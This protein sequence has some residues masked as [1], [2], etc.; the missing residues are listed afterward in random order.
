MPFYDDT[1]KYTVKEVSEILG[2]GEQSLRYYDRAGLLQPFYRDPDNS[3]RYYTINQFYRLELLK[4]A[5][6]LG[7]TVPE[8]QSLLITDDEIET[9]DF[10]QTEHVVEQLLEQKRAEI[11]TARRCIDE[12]DAMRRNFR[13]LHQGEIN[14]E[15]F[16]DEAPRRLA[17]AVEWASSLEDTSVRLRSERSRFRELLTEQYGFIL[18]P[19]AALEGRLS[20]LKEYV[21]LR[22]KPE[23]DDECGGIICLPSGPCTCFLYHCFLP[24]EPLSSL[25]AYLQAHGLPHAPLL[26]DELNFYES[27]SRITHAVRIFR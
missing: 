18:D 16:H 6:R 21:V 3:Y 15:P 8:Y 7:L 26:A 2:I 22:G 14:G 4:C 27:V 5:K 9:H 24:E 20:I 11:D 23:R 17:F 13:T 1:R 19:Q 25:A 10:S 12:L